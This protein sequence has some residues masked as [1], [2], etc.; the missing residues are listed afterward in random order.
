MRQACVIETHRRAYRQKFLQSYRK[1][2]LGHSSITEP[3][4][5]GGRPRSAIGQQI[6]A[7]LTEHPEGLSAE[8]IRGSLSPGKPIGDTLSGMKRLGT[9][10]TRG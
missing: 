8:Q 1:A 7:L 10:Q 4:R 5:K 9:V 6:L 2:A 3:A